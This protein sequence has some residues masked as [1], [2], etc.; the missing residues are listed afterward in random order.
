MH[1]RFNHHRR[2]SLLT[3]QTR[4]SVRS[5]ARQQT[6]PRSLLLRLFPHPRRRR[7]IKPRSRRRVRSSHRRYRRVRRRRNTRGSLL[8]LVSLRSP[9]VVKHARSSIRP[10]LRRVSPHRAHP[11]RWSDP[12]RRSRRR[13][14]SHTRRGRDSRRRGSASRRA[15]TP[16]RI[17]A[18][19]SH[20]HS[21]RW[22]W[23]RRT[24]RTG[25]V[26]PG[27]ATRG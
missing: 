2:R 18:L 10:T 25:G 26:R 21:R 4:P 14:G 20:A 7:D 8:S 12:R 1:R 11:R 22:R 9:G 6:R 17:R 23:R 13:P 3:Q 27:R 24:R 16:T 5:H 15:S 19:H